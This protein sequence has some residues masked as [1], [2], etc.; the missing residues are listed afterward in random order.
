MERKSGKAGSV[1]KR[2]FLSTAVTYIARRQWLFRLMVSMR[3]RLGPPACKTGTTRVGVDALGTGE[4]RDARTGEKN[5]RG[6][7]SNVH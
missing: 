4:V 5:R 1:K 3:V 6:E 7:K 2:T